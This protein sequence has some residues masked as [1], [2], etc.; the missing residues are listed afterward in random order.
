MLRNDSGP[1]RYADRS[2]QMSDE[3]LRILRE[4]LAAQ[5]YDRPEIIEVIAR[6]ILRSRDLYV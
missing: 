6:A 5:Y 4:R 1:V 3:F 2:I